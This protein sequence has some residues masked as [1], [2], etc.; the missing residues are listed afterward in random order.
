MQWITSRQLCHDY[1]LSWM[2]AEQIL[3]E[4]SG[5]FRKF[6]DWRGWL[7]VG[8]HLF[9]FCWGVFGARVAFPGAMRGHLALLELPG[10]VVVAVALLV[11]PRLLFAGEILAAARAHAGSKQP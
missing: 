1:E 2:T 6:G 7:I 9:G 10:L 3:R 8:L 4:Q 11:L 5:V